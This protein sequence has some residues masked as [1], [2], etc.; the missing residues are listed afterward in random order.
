MF[1]FGKKSKVKKLVKQALSDNILTGVEIK[2]IEAAADEANVSSDVI[3]K[4]RQ[5]HYNKLV[6]PTLDRIRTNRRFSPA[7]EAEIRSMSEQLHV[8]PE[9]SDFGPYRKL[10]EIEETGT[11]EP[12]PIDVNIRL[13]KNEVCFYSAPSI[14][15]QVKTIRKH[16]GYVGGSIG[17]RV[18]KGVTLRV[19]KAVPH[20]TESEEVVDISE[21]TLF[22]TNKKVVFDGDRRSTNI[23]F[24]RLIA[25]HLYKDAIEIRKSSGKPDLFR[26][27]PIDLEFLDALLQVIE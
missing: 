4:I 1:G 19:G 9:F 13:T 26:L 10:W 7:D 22:V 23:T 21:G 25:Y 6:K 15:A 20:Y 14:W 11:F 3:N 8:T 27:N 2:E 5:K 17:V 16:H 12:E 24:G 18:A